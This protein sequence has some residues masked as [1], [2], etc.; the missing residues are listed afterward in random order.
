MKINSLNKQEFTEALGG[1]FEHS[2]WVAERSW[3]SRPF[4]STAQLH[5][6]MVA[7]VAA[8]S[9]GEQLNLLLAHPDLG[10]RA[11]VS[12]SSAREQSGAGL[13][14][15]TQSEYENLLALNNAYKTRFGFPFI[16][17]V[18]GSDKFQILAALEQRLQ[19]TPDA[20][21]QTAL[22]Q[23]YR[24]AQFRLEGIS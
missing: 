16:Y 8:A 18:K 15:L 2:P 4:H 5:A 9:P 10:T 12:L 7:V 6:C 11:K 14:T 17:A 23:V 20:E 1:I 21:L 3:P 13:D 19:S 22:E 24:I